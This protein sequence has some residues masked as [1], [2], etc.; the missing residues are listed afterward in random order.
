VA[1]PSVVNRAAAVDQRF[2]ELLDRLEQEP[3][4]P[5]LDRDAPVR[6]GSLLTA[7]T[8]VAVFEAM[9][10]SRH[11]DFA[12]R[13]LK[14]QGA[15]YYTIGS[16]G[17]ETNA[18]LGELL[19]LDDWCFLHYRSG[20]LVVRR[21][22]KTPGETPLYD[23]CLSYCASSD[24]PIS[25]GRHKVWGS[26]RLRIPPQTSTIAS[27]LPKAVGCAVGLER[28]RR[29]GLTPEGE[30][31]DSIALVSFGDAS[32]NH[33]VAQTAINAALWTHHQGLPCPVI[34][35]CEDNGIGISVPTP[36]GWVETQYAARPGLHYVGCDGTDLAAAYDAA[37]EAIETCR[38][39]RRPVFLHMKVVRLLAHAGS[40]VETEYHTIAEIE[41]EEKRDPLLRAAE[42]L[43]RSGTLAARDVRAIYEDTRRRTAGAAREAAAR[44]RLTTLEQVVSSLAPST[45][46]AVLELARAVHEP[47]ARAAAWGG[48]ERLPERGRPKHL[49][50]AI[51]AALSDLLLQHPEAIVFGEDVGKKGGVYH[52]TADLQRVHGKARVF[53]TLL[54]ETSILGLAIGAAHVGLLPIPEIQYLAYLHNAEDQLRG[55]ACSLSFFSKGQFRNGMV[56]R[57]QGLGYQKGFGGHFHNDD[58][59]AVL[60][61][62]PGILVAVP[63]RPQD[64]VEMLRTCVAAAQVDGRVVVV[65]EPIALYMTKDLHAAGDQGWLAPYPAPGRA[66]PLGEAQVVLDQESPDLVVLTYGNGLYMALRTAKKL[67]AEGVKAR[68]VDLRWLVPID[69]AMCLKQA[70]EVGRVLV[71]DECRRTA[72][73]SEEILAAFV[74]EHLDVLVARVTAADTYVPL[75][76]AANLVLPSEEQILEAAR[77]LVRD[78]AMAPTQAL[79][80]LRE[81]AAP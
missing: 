25:G 31:E 11:L 62:I 15:G 38:F 41:A 69:R 12:A 50:A 71:L 43:V 67:E 34:F 45:P 17:H 32:V 5:P 24:D 19:R 22:Q 13:D 58:A 39:E 1:G 75:G 7:N 57:V 36:R 68:V 16:A 33:S 29:L 42:L 73:P 48:E 20:G 28:R 78:S 55:E 56:V 76:P 66:A 6:E 35:L 46:D 53:D 47:A 26:L 8:A 10:A 70:K 77:K 27:Q 37:S 23:T 49:A 60:R 30:P 51:N 81:G 64:A 74:E 72:G 2:L 18:V 21:A 65:L 79:R 61:D 4:P 40:D 54:D 9:V 59:I 80:A 3:A 44:P 14:A 52:V 63:A